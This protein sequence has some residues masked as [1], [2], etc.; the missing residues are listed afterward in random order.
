MYIYNNKKDRKLF[1]QHLYSV[2]N[3]PFLFLDSCQ[4]LNHNLTLPINIFLKT[5]LV[6]VFQTLSS[7]MDD[8]ADVERLNA[9]LKTE[10]EKR[11]V[12]S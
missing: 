3:L 11:Q 4:L 6:H 9:I 5:F 1:E 12:S 7:K 10:S 2:L 8:S